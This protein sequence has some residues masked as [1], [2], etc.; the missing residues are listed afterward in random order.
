MRNIHSIVKDYIK[1]VV[2]KIII[3][4]NIVTAYKISSHPS[5][6]NLRLTWD[7]VSIFELFQHK[8]GCII[9]LEGSGEIWGKSQVGSNEKEYD[10]T[11][12][13]SQKWPLDP[14]KLQIVLL[15]WLKKLTGVI[16]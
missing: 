1:F 5:S 8:K 7:S 16:S 11:R 2:M 3:L 6:M 4:S 12:I 9:G 10:L 15:C 14:N 13:T